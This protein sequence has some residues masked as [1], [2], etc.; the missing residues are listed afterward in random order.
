[1]SNFA[2][3]YANFQNLSAME[4]PLGEVPGFF[5]TNLESE[6][7]ATNEPYRNG[8]NSDTELNDAMNQFCFGETGR[9]TSILFANNHTRLIETIMRCDTTNSWRYVT[10]NI[11]EIEYGTI[12]KNNYIKSA[13]RTGHTTMIVEDIDTDPPAESTIPT[14]HL[15][16]NPSVPTGHLYTIDEI[17]TYINSL[18]DNAIIVVDETYL[19]FTGESWI[20]NSIMSRFD[21]DGA[22]WNTKNIRVVVVC[23]WTRFFP[24][25]ITS[26][27]SIVFGPGAAGVFSAMTVSVSYNHHPS[28][29]ARNYLNHSF[30][31]VDYATASW[32]SVRIWRELMVAQLKLIVPMWTFRGNEAMPWIWMRAGDTETVERLYGKLL[33]KGISIQK[34]D[35]LGGDSQCLAVRIAE[36]TDLEDFYVTF[37][38]FAVP[39]T[40]GQSFNSFNKLVST[41][42]INQT[43]I[44]IDK[45]LIQPHKHYS[46]IT[47]SKYVEMWSGDGGG[48]G[49]GE[50]DIEDCPP[51]I[52]SIFYIGSQINYFIIDGHA[53]FAAMKELWPTSTIP[54]ML[55]DYSSIYIFADTI[56]HLPY[57]STLVADR[58]QDAK[59]TT[60]LAVSD[61]NLLP[62]TRNAHQV[63]C[64]GSLYP[65][66]VLTRIKDTDGTA[67]WAV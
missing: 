15:I 53:R 32:N 52:A 36:G 20:D 41:I 66:N 64:G 59:N 34:G 46:V 25:S 48:D 28:G 24:S 39:I 54:L 42:F 3:N 45:N 33:T 18:P 43:P 35:R 12:V 38:Q 55:V 14:F 57:T 26:I 50:M 31:G 11:P 9:M 58:N 17:S 16:S 49:G 47:Y 63:L 60:L 22:M 2:I 40:I 44:R 10:P 62:V 7:P 4:N 1:M 61:G 51:I 6:S 56:D 65:I 5:G 37:G 19:P 67:W 13:I 23:D 27:S 21:D 29:K 30:G 8:G